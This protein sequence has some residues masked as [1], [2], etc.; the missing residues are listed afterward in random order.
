M[1]ATTTEKLPIQFLR[2]QHQD[3]SVVVIP[4]DESRFVITVGEAIRAC[5]AFDAQLQ[6]ERQFKEVLNKLGAWVTT[7]KAEVSRAYITS[8]DTGLL[9]LVVR[10]VVEYGRE[11]EDALTDLDVDVAQN[12]NLDLV[13]LSVLAIPK[14]SD[15]SVASFLNPKLTLAFPNAE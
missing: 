15:E 9:F 5:R 1:N 10:N 7:H 11:F 12:P 14:A 6:F 4:E 2:Y 13:Q 3:G 8:R